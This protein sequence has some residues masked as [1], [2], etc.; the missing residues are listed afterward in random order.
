MKTPPPR[1]SYLALDAWRGIASLMVVVFHT[2][3]V[4]GFHHPALTALPFFR[5]AEYGW[6]GVQLFFVISGFCIANAAVISQYRDPHVGSFFL[7]RLRRIFP[8]YWCALALFL[9]L[10]QLTGFLV[11]RGVLPGNGLVGAERLSFVGLAF[12]AT[13]T[14]LIFHTPAILPVSWTLCFE[15]AFYGLVGLALG[16]VGRAHGVRSMLR[17]LH[18][19]TLL[20]LV[21][22]LVFGEAVPYPFS[23]WAQFGLGVLVFDVLASPQDTR[24]V[25]LWSGAILATMAVVLSVREFNVFDQSFRLS[26]IVTALFAALLI[27]LHRYDSTLGSH[28]ALKGLASIGG[29]SYSLYLTHHFVLRVVLQLFD[30]LHL[31]DPGGLV[32][33]VF[34]VVGSVI[35][36]A[37]FYRLCEKPFLK[38]RAAKPSS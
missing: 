13:L 23:M 1:L 36:A 19:L 15:L 14:H 37:L 27:G 26:T 16:V 11:A 28:R 29:F 10:L 18:C 32:G 3:G 4:H 8:P 31:P 30:K 20:C 9:L 7:A 24:E 5:A 35:V 6:L 22:L 38:K 34:G 21:A 17:A 2:A 33:V 25:R 12:N